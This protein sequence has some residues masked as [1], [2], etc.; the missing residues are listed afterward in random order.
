MNIP[1]ILLGI[2][3]FGAGYVPFGHFVSADGTQVELPFHLELAIPPVTVGLIGIFI[4]YYF[5]A[6]ENGKALKAQKSFGAL[7]NWAYNKFYIDEIYL[8]VTKKVLFNLV[9]RP[10]AWIDRNIVDGMINGS[11]SITAFSSE[12]IKKIQSGSVQSYAIYFLGGVLAVAAL[13][14]Y[15]YA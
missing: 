13:L 6:K 10:A 7:Y 2:A 4:A 3:A 15:Y 9:G 5:F 12:S 11:A 1:L 8:F 14:I